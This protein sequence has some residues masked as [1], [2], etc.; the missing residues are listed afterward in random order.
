ML[1]IEQR[2]LLL[3]AARQAVRAAAAGC[4]LPP[5]PAGGGFDSDSGAFVTLRRRSGGGLRGCIGSFSA[6][7]TL[8]RTVVWLAAAAA[9]DDP[10]FAPVRPEEV[11]G[12][13][14]EISVLGPMVPT[15]P[16]E[17]VPG[18]HGVYVK[19]GRLGGTLLPQVASEEGWGREQLLSH[20]CMKAG[21]PPDAWKTG[22]VEIYAYTAEVFS[23]ES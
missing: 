1:T 17:I 18:V 11:P 20:T 15:P 21:L 13:R 14:I 7:G 5:A 12:L 6:A 19:S 3:D 8:G 4:A 16:G 9:A 2:T 10:R 23:D 22:E